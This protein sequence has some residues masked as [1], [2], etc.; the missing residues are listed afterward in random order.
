LRMRKH[1][2]STMVSGTDFFY[3]RNMRVHLRMRKNLGSTM[4]I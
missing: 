2:G 3:Y 4:V 1:S